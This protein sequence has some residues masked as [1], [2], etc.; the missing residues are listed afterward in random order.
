MGENQDVIDNINKKYYNEENKRVLSDKI[1][2]STDGIN[3]E[4]VENISAKYT[5][6]LSP[7][8]VVKNNEAYLFGRYSQATGDNYAYP[9]DNNVLFDTYVISL[10]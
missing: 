1:Y 9:V 7:A 8:I 3:W 4:Q 6:R 5:A 10:K 2:R